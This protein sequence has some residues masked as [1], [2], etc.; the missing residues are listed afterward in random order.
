MNPC[1]STGFWY[2]QP[3]SASEEFFMD[4]IDLIMGPRNTNIDQ[5]VWNEV[6]QSFC[7]TIF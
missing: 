3:T 5:I 1:M 7:N 6:R 2:I 4:Y